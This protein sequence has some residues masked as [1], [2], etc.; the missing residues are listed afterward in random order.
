VKVSV[1]VRGGGMG[2]GSRISTLR[3]TFPC[4]MSETSREEDERIIGTG[5]K[6]L[7]SLKRLMG[8]LGKSLRH[9][10]LIDLLLER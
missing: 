7:E 9:L 4:D 8:S 10:Q 6:L 3:F 2:I 1:E 5:G